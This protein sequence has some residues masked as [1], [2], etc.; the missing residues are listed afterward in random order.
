MTPMRDP[1]SEP[2]REGLHPLPETRE[3]IDELEPSGEVDDV[4]QDL[5][6]SGRQIRDLV[7]DCVGLSLATTAHGVTLTLVASDHEIALLDALQYVDSGP[8]V[9][10]VAAEQVITF[11]RDGPR[12]AESAPD[13]EDRWQLF[14]L[15]TAAAGV[16]STLTLPLLDDDQVVGS[17]NLYAASTGAFD[18]LHAEIADILSAWAPGAVLNADLPFSS[19]ERAR[20]APRILKNAAKVEVAI[21]LLLAS[22]DLDEHEARR[23]FYDAAGRGG[24][25][26]VR[27][28]EV[29]VE[30]LGQRPSS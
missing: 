13:W 20:Q 7:P 19:R 12:P 27:L 4:L 15:A 14:A 5:L 25:E 29:L 21:G 11:D 16:R 2:W 18:G 26:D 9:D 24:V 1:G 23:R 6:E 30:L 3:A 22:L 28:A 8:C 10:A 17:V